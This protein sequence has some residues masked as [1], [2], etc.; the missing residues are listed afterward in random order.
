VCMNKAAHASFRGLAWLDLVQSTVSC[1]PCCDCSESMLLWFSRVLYT[2]QLS[3]LVNTLCVLQACSDTWHPQ[4]MLQ[5]A[6]QRTLQRLAVQANLQDSL[7]PA[8]PNP[9]S[10]QS[11]TS[12]WTASLPVPLSS[13]T[14]CSKA[15]PWSCLT[16]PAQQGQ[17]RWVDDANRQAEAFMCTEVAEANLYI[18]NTVACTSV[19]FSRLGQIS[20]FL[21][22]RLICVHPE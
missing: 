2:L 1:S 9:Q 20:R 13:G 3:T 19:A 8:V 21:D 11:S 12:T 10:G 14:Q 6:H 7:L 15:S 22:C 17:G 5:R 4:N 16:Q 18:S